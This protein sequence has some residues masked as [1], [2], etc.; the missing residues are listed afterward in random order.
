VF[1]LRR[2]FGVEA[3]LDLH[4]LSIK[5]VAHELAA[6]GFEVISAT[7]REPLRGQELPMRRGFVLARRAQ[8]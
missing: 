4:F 2:W 3:E 5:T 8:R 1:R 6:S 7:L